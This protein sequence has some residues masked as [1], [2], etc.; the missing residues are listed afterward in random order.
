M[1][2]SGATSSSSSFTPSM[3]PSTT[4]SSA[5]TQMATYIASVPFLGYSEDQ[6]VQLIKATFTCF[7][8]KQYE[9]EFK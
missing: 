3:T 6:I 8:D 5:L 1:L 2:S 4:P 9:N 7:W